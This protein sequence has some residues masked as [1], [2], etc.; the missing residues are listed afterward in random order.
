MCEPQAPQQSN[1]Q[2]MFVYNYNMACRELAG[3]RDSR[4]AL[5]HS[6]HSVT[7]KTQLWFQESLED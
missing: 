3:R 5:K 1:E 6:E 2:C 4:E 7:S